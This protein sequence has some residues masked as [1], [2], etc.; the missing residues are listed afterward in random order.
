MRQ[1]RPLPNFATVQ[2]S[3][4]H[5]LI[6]AGAAVALF[7]T[8]A[9]VFAHAR[10]VRSSPTAN[11]SLPTPPDRIALWF[12]ERP[13]LRF[14]SVQLLDSAGRA[15]ALGAPRVDVDLAGVVAAITAPLGVGRYTV[16]WRTAAADGHPTTGKFAFTVT[17]APATSPVVAPAGASPDSVSVRIDTVARRIPNSIVQPDRPPA[18]PTAARWAE[19]VAALSVIG[20]LIVRLAVLPRADLPSETFIDASDRLRRL[21]HATLTLFVLATL[22]RVAAESTLVMGDGESRL[23]AML[24]AVRDTRWGHGWSFGA[25]G[26]VLAIVGLFAARRSMSGW[27]AAAVGAVL[28]CLGEALTG[29]AAASSRSAL[30]IAAD[31]THVLGAGGWIGGLAALLLSVFP[32]IG[33]QEQAQESR[34]GSRVVRAYHATAVES[35]AIVAISALVAA[36][37]RLPAV[38]ALWSTTY[39]RILL[40]KVCVVLVVLAFGGYH[41][42]SAVSVEWGAGTAGKFRRSAAAELVVGAI[43]VAITAVLISTPLPT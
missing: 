37:L 3:S 8:P 28:V 2:S 24:V 33:A 26:A 12:S 34:V 27:V 9:I 10:L 7:I 21:G 11:A 5:A 22:M 16:V 38:N 43:V 41:Y 42:R 35:V 23:H 29:H 14:T 19:L 25:A 32:A 39:G 1:T 30:A 15:I 18:M 4:R 40:I 36:W 31:V 13:E 6:A 17:S 20:A